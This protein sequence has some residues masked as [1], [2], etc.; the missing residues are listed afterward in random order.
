[1]ARRPRPLSATLLL[2]AGLGASPAAAALPES[3]T[4]L[5][6]A[7][8][9]SASAATATT[10]RREPFEPDQ[11]RPSPPS[12][13]ASSPAPHGPAIDVTDAT[14]PPRR[15][16]FD[17]SLVRGLAERIRALGPLAPVVFVLLFVLNTV[18]CLPTSVLAMTGGFLFGPMLGMACVWSGAV[19][20]ASA[21]FGISRR[22]G[23]GWIQRRIERHPRLHAVEQA[24]SEEGWRIVILSRLAPGSPFFLLNFMFGLTRI[25]FLPY[26]WST[27]VSIVPGTFLFVYLGS[28]GHLALEER[29]RTPAEWVLYFAGLA[30]LVLAISLI[31]RRAQRLLSRRLDPPPP[32]MPSAD[33]PSGTKPAPPSG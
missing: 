2:A 15:A 23:R 21:A 18:L 33:T 29:V 4:A 22:M 1:M 27:A 8:T 24:V 10:P 7:V 32:S 9:A 6:A 12:R 25:R 31:T 16:G 17:S 5:P 3:T 26:L 28:L 20:G 14:D 30:A 11:P 19:A 13:A